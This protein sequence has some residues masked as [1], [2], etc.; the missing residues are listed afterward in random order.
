MLLPP[1]TP[2]ETALAMAPPFGVRSTATYC[3]ADATAAPSTRAATDRRRF[4]LRVKFIAEPFCFM[5]PCCGNAEKHL[6]V[7]CQ[8]EVKSGK[9]LNLREKE[10]EKTTYRSRPRGSC[11]RNRDRICSCGEPGVD[12]CRS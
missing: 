8:Q 4:D 9:R 7:R 6:S 12:R 3:W 1:A 2:A 10:F 11:D 5:S